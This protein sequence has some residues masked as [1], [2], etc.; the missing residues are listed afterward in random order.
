VTDDARGLLAAIVAEPA[1]DTAR[2]AYA[3][4]IEEG[5]NPA[6]AA[7]I[8][9]Q[10]E[11]E[12]LHPD[13]NARLALERS[14]EALFAEHWIDWW[15]EVCAAVGLPMPAPKPISRLERLASRFRLGT[16]PGTPYTRSGCMV[17]IPSGQSL[18]N[19]SAATFHC[20]FPD[21]LDISVPVSRVSLRQRATLNLWE[22][23]L[24]LA[25]LTATNPF[26]LSL[27][28]RPL[29]GVHA[30][31]LLDFDGESLRHLLQSPLFP[32]LEDLT[33]FSGEYVAEGVIVEEFANQTA[34]A[35]R[36]LRDRRLKRLSLQVWSDAAATAVAEA[37]HL[38][39]LEALDVDI[40]PDVSDDYEGAT[41]RLARLVRSPHLASLKELTVSGWPAR[42]WPAAARSRI[43]CTAA[44]WPELRKLTINADLGAADL[45][46]HPAALL[47]GATLPALEELRV[48]AIYLNR[49]AI[50]HLI[51]SPLLKQLRH[52][53]LSAWGVDGVS[54]ADLRRLPEMFD[55]DRIETFW[56]NPDHH[57]P[58]LDELRRQLGDRLRML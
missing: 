47:E 15:A 40:L 30:L 19:L 35:V 38:A 54:D 24:P 5:G 53:A 37:P 50:D 44:T 11:A 43:V 13:S 57:R 51:R 48:R 45:D 18:D 33:L 56:F 39:S 28:E 41:W 27:R 25:S 26:L 9:V 36:L 6:R 14:A 58:G 42:G 10:I 12:R 20:G 8:R 29:K 32:R 23:E 46:P 2:L 17:R 34:D 7:F 55:L 21:S 4:C 16:R 22:P 3:D 1:D 31:T 49:Q 52:F